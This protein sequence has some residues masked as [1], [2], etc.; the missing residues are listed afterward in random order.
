MSCNSI[1][2]CLYYN[3]LKAF[4]YFVVD[5]E[6]FARCLGV[7]CLGVKVSMF[8]VLFFF[9]ASYYSLHSTT[10]YLAKLSQ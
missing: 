7:C 8:F 10:K 5:G 4:V 2:N 3:R 1:Y 9:F 6:W